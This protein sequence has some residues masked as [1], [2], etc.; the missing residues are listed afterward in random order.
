MMRPNIRYH[1]GALLVSALVLLSGCAAQATTDYQGD[2]LFS[3]KGRV[4]VPLTVTTDQPLVPAIA[5]TKS[6]AVEIRIVQAEVSGEFPANFQVDLYA[7]P[8]AAVIGGYESESIPGEPRYTIGYISAVTADHLS[9]L[10]Y[11]QTLLGGEETC[12]DEGC[13]ITREAKSAFTD[14][15]GT[16]SIFCPHGVSDFPLSGSAPRCTLR[17]RTGDPMFVSFVDD[18]MFAGAADNY[19]VVYLEGPAKPGGYLSLIFGAPEGLAAG[20]HLLRALPWDVA[21]E[22]ARQQCRD[23]AQI[24]ATAKYNAA[25]GT[26]FGPDGVYSECSGATCELD[27]DVRGLRGEWHRLMAERDCPFGRRYML[28]PSSDA[29]VSLRI[30]PG[31]NFVDTTVAFPW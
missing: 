29:T 13:V 26:E 1:R 9:T 31:L 19:V 27:P 11:A 30:Q 28:E 23:Q 5:F 6:Y 16:V 20:Y 24:D 2:P 10:Y 25:H 8:P 12:D 14:R 18:P 4:E 15:K 7:P 3:M 21:G 22:D 17:A